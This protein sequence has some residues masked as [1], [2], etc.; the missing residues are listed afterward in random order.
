MDLTAV[1]DATDHGD[2]VEKWVGLTGTVTNWLKSFLQDKDLSLII[3]LG[4]QKL[5]TGF[6]LEVCSWTSV[7]IVF[8]LI[9]YK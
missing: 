3:S 6:C 7:S 5:Q 8:M 4:E 1:F 9:Y 2:D